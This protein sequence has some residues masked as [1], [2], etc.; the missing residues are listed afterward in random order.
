MKIRSQILTLAVAAAGFASWNCMP[1]TAQTATSPSISVLRTPIEGDEATV[2]LDPK[3]YPQGM[4][5]PYSLLDKALADNV[6]RNGN[7]D[8]SKLTDNK[9]LGYFIQ[10][11]EHADLSQFPTFDVYKTDEKTGRETKKVVDH[12]PELVFWINAYN[13]FILNDIAKAYPVKTIDEIKDFDTAKTHNVAGTK[14]SLKELREKVASFG[15]P[16]AM[17]ALPSGTAGGFLPSPTAVRWS[18]FDD[19]MNSAVRVFINDPRNVR[20]SRIQNQVTLNPVFKEVDAIFSSKYSRNKGEGI[21]KALAG[22]TNQGSN[23]SY[24]VTGKYRIDYG[25]ENRLINDKRNDPTSGPV[26]VQR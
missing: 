8:Y 11:V 3:D 25:Q 10:A 14:Y 21:R 6:D 13:A 4:L 7:V 22:Y 12:S 9:H 1:V 5:F 15:D 23:R 26:D 20:V 19:R 24:F 17:F 18:E 2:P 16:R